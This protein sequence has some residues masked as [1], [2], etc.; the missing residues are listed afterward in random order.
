V[1]PGKVVGC[2]SLSSF[3]GLFGFSLLPEPAKNW[4]KSYSIPIFGVQAGTAIVTLVEVDTTS[5]VVVEVA[6]TVDVKV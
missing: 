2:G 1:V 6:L 4:T 3:E 5:M